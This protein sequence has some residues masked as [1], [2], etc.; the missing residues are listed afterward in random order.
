MSIEKENIWVEPGYQVKRRV[1]QDPTKYAD[2]TESERKQL[3]DLNEQLKTIE[4]RFQQL[5]IQTSKELQSRVENPSD[6][7][8][9]FEIELTLDFVLKE[10][11]LEWDDDDDNLLITL[12]YD[13]KHP[14]TIPAYTFGDNQTNFNYEPQCREFD[15]WH[16]WVY[17]ELYDHCH[18][19]WKNLLR[20]GDILVDYQVTQQIIPFFRRDR[21]G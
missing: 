7:L 2:L 20:I 18:V 3:L 4:E 5:A 1:C 6:W 21:N 9:D 14:N 15:E 19:G 16:C 8:D 17:H 13:L 12:R 10:E 11:D